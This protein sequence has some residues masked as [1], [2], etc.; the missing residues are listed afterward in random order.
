MAVTRPTLAFLGAGRVATALGLAWQAR[1]YT[2]TA[3]GSRNPASARRLAEQLA[4]RV[5]P[6]PQADL[7][8]LSVPDD[9]IAAVA[10][11]WLGNNGQGALIHTSGVHSLALFPNI[12][13]NQFGTFHPAYPFGPQT[14]LTGE[15]GLLIGIEA[16]S[17]ELSQ[18]LE[19]VALDLGGRPVFLPADAKAR[20]HLAAVVASN[21][22]VT[23]F[24]FARSLY[25]QVGVPAELNTAT[26]LTLM[27]GAL[28]NLVVYPPAQALT[29]PIARGDLATLH[30]HL[31][32]L[33]QTPWLALYCQLG[34]HTVD[35]APDLQP[36]QRQQIKTLLTRL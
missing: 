5:E 17:A 14:R 28:Q 19:G 6:F 11:A 21:Y 18:M 20:Y 8:F 9:Q 25:A 4:C 32:A 34:L 33:E 16:T 24:E 29:G 2:I 10:R 36:E 26:V 27:Q 3:V 23:L 15:E 35:L 1:G 12:S 13:Q 30:L 22:L 7:V 31:A